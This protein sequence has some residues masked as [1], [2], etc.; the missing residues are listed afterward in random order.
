[1]M[2]SEFHKRMSVSNLETYFC[3]DNYE[4]LIVHVFHKECYGF[5]LGNTE[6]H[7]TARQIILDKNNFIYT[8]WKVARKLAN[9][10]YNNDEWTEFLNKKKRVENHFL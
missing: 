7:A 5:D 8:G 6:E 1:M 4:Y 9:W 3:E 2:N 10:I